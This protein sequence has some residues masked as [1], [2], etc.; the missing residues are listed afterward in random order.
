MRDMGPL[1]NDTILFMDCGLQW[2]KRH[3]ND[4][5]LYSN[6]YHAINIMYT[7]NI[8]A[9]FWSLNSI[10]WDICQLLSLRKSTLATWYFRKMIIMID[11]HNY[12]NTKTVKCFALIVWLKSLLSPEP[13]WYDIKRAK[14]K[15]PFSYE[16]IFFSGG[17]KS[18]RTLFKIHH[19]TKIKQWIVK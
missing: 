9:N 8:S 17:E 18:W 12:M 2:L 10:E 7:V 5:L 4:P 3:C 19:S 14:N 6:R 15:N 13:N 11:W 16:S 1:P